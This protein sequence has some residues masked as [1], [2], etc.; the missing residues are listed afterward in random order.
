MMMV[1]IAIHTLSALMMAGVIWFVQLVHYPLFDRVGEREFGCFEREHVRRTT[2]IVAPLMIAEASS[3]IGLV[4]LFW[5]SPY[6]GLL[7]LGLLLLVVIWASTAFIQVPCHRKL[8]K[9][10]DLSVVQRLV[11]TN[12]IRTTAWTARGFLAIL[13]MQVIQP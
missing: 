6:R 8:N 13:I 1:V 4:L 10:L 7:L 2:W 12:W 3:A 11:W 9:G 5:S